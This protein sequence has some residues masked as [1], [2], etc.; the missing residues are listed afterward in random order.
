MFDSTG[1]EVTLTGTD[2]LTS[3]SYLTADALGNMWVIGKNRT[4]RRVIQLDAN[5]NATGDPFPSSA[6]VLPSTL[7]ADGSGNV[8]GCAG[9]AN[10]LDTF[11]NGVETGSVMLANA[12]GCNSQLV[13]DGLGNIFTVGNDTISS[14]LQIDEYTSAGVAITPATGYTGTSSGEVP[15]LN[16]DPNYGGRVPGIGAAI[17]RSGNLWVLNNDTNGISSQGNV[18]VEFVGIAAPVVTPPSVALS[19]VQLGARP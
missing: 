9:A 3:S 12:Q 14:V 5:G 19:P 16:P 13:M 15:T 8:Y 4:Q 1:T 17:D 7:V 18:L 2:P 6:P 11:N 10:E